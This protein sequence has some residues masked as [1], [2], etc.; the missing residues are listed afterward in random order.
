MF[1]EIAIGA[2]GIGIVLMVGYLI[3]AQ[4][5]NSVSP[6]SVYANYQNSCYGRL[7]NDTTYC[8]TTAV[9]CGPTTDNVS[10]LIRCANSGLSTGLSS[11]QTTIFAGFG[12]LAVGVIVLAAFS[13]IKVFQ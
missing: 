9:A 8:N 6:A 1:M 3:I 4:V 10:V 13:L 2:I 5:Y 7:N 11:A 12:L